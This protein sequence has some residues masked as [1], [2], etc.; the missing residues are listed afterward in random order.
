M[1]F[2][3]LALLAF[4]AVTGCTDYFQGTTLVFEFDQLDP[5][6]QI[7]PEDQYSTASGTGELC[8]DDPYVA[9]TWLDVNQFNQRYQQPYEY[10]AWATINGGPV[11]L[12]RFTVR[13]CT[14]N[15]GDFEIKPAVTTIN[16]TRDPTYLS[17]NSE[18]GSHFYGSVNYVSAPVVLGSA[19]MNTEVRLEQATEVFVT[20]EEI[21]ADATEVDLATGPRGTLLMRGSL[22]RENQVITA[23]LDK[24][25][26]SATGL[27]TAIPADRVSAW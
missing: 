20:R 3:L 7:K 1:R 14:I 25:N 2:C 21:P 8:A 26:G 6:H 10:H 9:S 19:T 16:Y 18:D 22:V 4:T 27:V 11:R 13:D 5:L 17:A 24:V 23:K 12:V 15:S